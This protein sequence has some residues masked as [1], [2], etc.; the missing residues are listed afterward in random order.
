ML[1]MWGDWELSEGVPHQFRKETKASAGVSAPLPQYSGGRRI[2]TGFS[3]PRPSSR[4]AKDGQQS[5]PRVH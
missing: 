1:K 3:G 5:G 4:G 2:K